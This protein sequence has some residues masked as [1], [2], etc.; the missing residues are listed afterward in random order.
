[1]VEK[2]EF[3]NVHN[4][5]IADIESINIKPFEPVPIKRLV[6]KP[7]KED[8]PSNLA[9]IG[10]YILPFEIMEILDR[11]EIGVGNEIQLTDALD[12]LL[13]DKRLD[14]FLTDA[15]IFDCGSSKGFIGAN[16]ALAIQDKEMLNYIKEIIEIKKI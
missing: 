2:V 14:A 10:R 7:K 5:G 11:T 4:Y 13:V 12:T 3:D 8:A 16:V 9:I 15:S 1:M 6:E